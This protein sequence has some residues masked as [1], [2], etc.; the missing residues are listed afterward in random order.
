MSYLRPDAEMTIRTTGGAP[1][2]R[3]CHGLK[4]RFSCTVPVLWSPHSYNDLAEN[5]HGQELITSHP[6]VCPLSLVNKMTPN[7]VKRIR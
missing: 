4:T 1:G 5:V 2:E 7:G 6:P 3:F